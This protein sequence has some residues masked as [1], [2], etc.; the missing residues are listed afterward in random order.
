M[1]Y[2][3]RADA[4]SSSS[5]EELRDLLETLHFNKNIDAPQLTAHPSLRAEDMEEAWVTDA[6]SHGTHENV[7]NN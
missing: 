2:T 7:I 3:F 1:K 4:T 5:L 6:A